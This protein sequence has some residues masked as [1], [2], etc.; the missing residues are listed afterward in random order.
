MTPHRIIPLA[1][2]T[3]F[4]GARPHAVSLVVAPD[5]VTAVRL[6][7]IGSFQPML[8]C[9]VFNTPAE[10]AEALEERYA[11]A[12]LTW[13]DLGTAYTTALS[14][15]CQDDPVAWVTEQTHGFLLLDLPRIRVITWAGAA[16]TEQARIVRDWLSLALPDWPVRRRGGGGDAWEVVV[17]QCE[18]YA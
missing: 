12:V 18:A 15:G 1:T 10:A 13:D 17:G 3:E 4:P 8:D 6:E 11:P 14:D 7:Q 9:A 5:G 2:L 16:A